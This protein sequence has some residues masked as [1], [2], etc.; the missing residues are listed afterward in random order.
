M[1]YIKKLEDLIKENNGTIVTSDLDKFNIPRIYL[2]KLMDMGKIERVKR[3]V[4]VAVGEIEDEM[5]YMQTKYSKLIYSHETALF[6]HELTDRTPFEYS[7]T[8]PSGYK[9][10]QNVS[11]NNKIY[12]IKRELHLLGVVTAKTSF[13]NEIKVYDVERTICDI[14]RSRERIDIQ[15]VTQALKDYVRLKTTDFNKLSEYAK[16]FRVNEILRKYMEVLL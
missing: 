13:G 6:I 10:P 11:D 4:Y 2:T 12:Y 15:I 14:L 1:D 5:F 9:A 16:V 8:V 7:V 3:G